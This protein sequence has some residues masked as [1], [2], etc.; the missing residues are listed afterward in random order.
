[1][2]EFVDA[3]GSKWVGTYLDTANMMAYGYPEQW[4]RGLGKRIKKIHFKDFKRREHKFVNLLDG[5]TDWP[6]VMK[7]LRNIGFDTAAVH[8]VGGDR[9]MLVDLGDRMRKIVAM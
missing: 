3:V 8:E 1:M 2:R 9:E 5:D 6:L 7:E 4:I